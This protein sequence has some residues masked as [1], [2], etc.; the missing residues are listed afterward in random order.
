MHVIA[1][2]ARPSEKGGPRELFT[3]E[4]TTALVFENGGVLRLSAAVVPGQL[5]FLTHKE[6]KREVVAQ[7][8]RKR[9]FRPMTCYVEVE[10]SE[11]SPG[12]WGIDF[13]EMPALLPAS[14]QQRSAAESV[15][16]EEDLVAGEPGEPTAA[17]SAE[18][19]MALKDEVEVL[20]EHLK[21]LQAQSAPGRL[22]AP[23][24]TPDLSRPTAPEPTRAA[25]NVPTQA[26]IHADASSEPQ[27]KP[28]PATGDVSQRSPTEGSGGLAGSAAPLP[29]ASASL[30]VDGAEPR[31]SEDNLL[32]KPA[33]NFQ[34]A[35]PPVTLASKPAQLVAANS[36]RAAL[37]KDMLFAAFVLITAGAAW[38]QNLLPGLPQRKNVFP[39]A[40]SS[41]SAHPAPQAPPRTVNAGPAAAKSAQTSESLGVP[42]STGLPD[43]SQAA[44][45]GTTQSSTP[46]VAETPAAVNPVPDAAAD[47]PEVR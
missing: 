27:L 43:A 4:T 39:S 47:T 8:T 6:S 41:A 31:F 28:R 7:V 44:P 33:L 11:P 32:P 17:P 18:E 24:V 19:V 15:Q 42:Q 45:S 20:R 1:T 29:S 36:Q 9:N 26:P 30:S 5:L 23:A 3:E 2:G 38:Y 37:R 25:V 16:P 46:D 21:L 34:D 14:A 13:P 12:F 22:P 40:A 35:K 10:F